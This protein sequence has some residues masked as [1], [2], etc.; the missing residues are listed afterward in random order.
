V[1]SVGLLGVT[2]ERQT[3]ADTATTLAARLK[4]ITDVPVLVG[5]GVSNAQQAVQASE[6]ADGVIQGAAV[7]RRMLE[8]GPEAVGEFVADVRQALD[9]RFPGIKS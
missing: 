2:G 7:V 4:A 6:V 5:V 9:Q 3:L 8:G 1:Y